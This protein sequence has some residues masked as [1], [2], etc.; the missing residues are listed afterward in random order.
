MV[1]DM[2]TVTVQK[3]IGGRILTLETGKVAKQ[4]AGAVVVSYGETVVLAAVA[5][6]DPREGIDFFPLTVD[7]REKT[8][9][10][11]KFPGGFFKREGRPTTKEILTMRMIDRPIRPLFPKGYKDEVLI[12][13]MV[14]SA[15]LE[16][17]PDILAMVGASA[18]LSLSPAP[19]DGPTAAVRVGRVDGQF[20]VNPTQQQLE[21]SDFD[22]L[23]SG[24]ADAV[25]M[26]E[27][28][29]H[30]VAESVVVDAVAFGQEYVRQICELIGELVAQA[31]QP[32]SYTPPAGLDELAD[33]VRQRC[34]DELR[35]LRQIPGKLERKEAMQGFYDQVIAEF[36]PP[37]QTD[38]PYTPTQVDEAIHELEEH[39]F[40]DLILSDGVRSDGRRPDELRQ[41]LCEVGVLPRTHGSALF[42]RGET[43]SMVVTTLG[44]VSDEQ[45]I[46]GLVEEYK[47]KF[48]LHYNFPS[49]CTGEVRMPR[50]PSRREIGHG[51]LAERSL[52][53]VV[54]DK[55]VFPYTIRLVSDI[56]ES[57]GSSSMASV[58]GGCL[59][60]M[61]AGV[62]IAEPVA[63]ISIGMVHDDQKAVLLT[64][65]IGEEDHFGDMDFKVAGTKNGITGIQVDLKTRGL[66]MEL[67]GQA[68]EAA[69]T[70]R[71]EI[72][73]QM[74]AVL[75]APREELS[76]HAPRLLTIRIDPEKIGKVIGPGGK[77]IRKLEADTGAHIDIEDD[78]TVF[79]SC[80]SAEGGQKALETIKLITEE[81]RV[82]ALYTGRVVSVRDFGAFI[83][84][85]PGQ[86][87]M[88]HISELSDQYVQNVEDVVKVGDEVRVKVLLID[89]QGRVK[90]SRKAAMAEEGVSD[91][92][93]ESSGPSRPR[94]DDRGRSGGRGGRR[95]G[96]GRGRR[97]D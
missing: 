7:Y 20:V 92:P 45:V 82:G 77:G 53:G 5:T 51:A 6:A 13:A 76:Q 57:N 68:L 52:E 69:R 64:D 32:K 49:F 62:P 90:L 50:G 78:G 34:A 94:R 65:I 38:L 96:G 54:P 67:I 93:I 75:P 31:G 1:D 97:R 71:L 10:A 26:L 95:D 46:D 40:R 43:Q 21:Q 3:E 73:R 44:T 55:D 86:D 91:P 80:L 29:G 30:Q 87:G 83:E 81:V 33:K 58:C 37:D 47:Q 25:N 15:D 28:G 48:M 66:S 61:D 89:E 88:C 8:S 85:L 18:A 35:R 19:F 4:A 9:A 27:L 74:L 36:C 23:V 84:I 16:N 24:H 41:I 56:L 72:L 11:G 63:G 2:K 22:L 59:A 70:A 60:L 17:D 42:T 12:Q 14:L 39:I 79:I